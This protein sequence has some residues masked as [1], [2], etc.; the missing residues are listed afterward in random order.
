MTLVLAVVRQHGSAKAIC[1][2]K[3]FS[4]LAKFSQ[5]LCWR[6]LK[7]LAVISTQKNPL[8]KNAF[9]GGAGQKE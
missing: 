7:Y 4:F 1:L 8:K 9:L 2:Y 5:K 3:I 6:L